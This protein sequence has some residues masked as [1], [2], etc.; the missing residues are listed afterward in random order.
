MDFAN[1]IANFDSFNLSNVW[2]VYNPSQKPFTYKND[3]A[4]ATLLWCTAVDIDKNIYLPY[5]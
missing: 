2:F 1:V 4:Y 3:V 5:D